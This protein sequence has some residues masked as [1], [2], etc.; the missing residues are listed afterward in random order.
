MAKKITQ[1]PASAGNPDPESLIDISEKIGASY[2]SKKLTIDQL[3]NYLTDNLNINQYDTFLNE[4]GSAF[5]I[6]YSL[7]LGLYLKN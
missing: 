3:L 7:V 6:G 1:Y 2:V 4:T 5:P